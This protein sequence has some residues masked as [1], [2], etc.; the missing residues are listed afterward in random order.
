MYS[1]R[2]PT[3]V[4][5]LPSHIDAPLLELPYIYP[6]LSIFVSARFVGI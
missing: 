6:V 1:V 3:D 2:F 4:V 5:I